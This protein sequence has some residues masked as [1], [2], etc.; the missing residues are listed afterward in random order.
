MIDARPILF[1]V[2]I[3]NAKQSVLGDVGTMD[4]WIRLTNT[5]FSNYTKEIFPVYNFSDTLNIDISMFLLSI[6]DFDEVSGVITLS[7]GIMLDWNDY[8][9]Q[10]TPSE[11]GGMETLQVNSSNVWTPK[12]YVITAADD[13]RH[14]G[15]GEFG[16]DISYSG[17]CDYTPGKLLKS[18]CSVDMSKFPLDTQICNIE[19]MLWKSPPTLNLSFTRT[20][21]LMNWYTTNGE[22]NIDKTNVSYFMGYGSPSRTLYFTLQM[23]RRYI[24][25]VVSMTMPILLLCFLNPFVFLLPSSSGERISYTI[26]MFLSLAVYMTLIGDILPKVSENMAGM[27]YFLLI[28]LFYSGMLIVLTIFT[29]RCEAAADVKEFPRW[30]RRLTRYCCKIKETKTYNAPPI[31]N[32]EQNKKEESDK[33]EVVELDAEYSLVKHK[34]VMRVIDNFLFGLSLL[35]ITILTIWFMCT[36]H[37]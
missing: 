29:L 6:I 17:R 12:V 31:K 21:I 23:S 37:S 36:Y 33:T 4:D 3:Y 30:L 35:L 1:M 7:A 24:Y 2:L 26:T 9:L 16:V 28:T 13:L 20:D 32:L 14:F 8:R 25:F 22:W 11:Y 27:S 18:T 5:L 10:W 19:M 15:S 34:D